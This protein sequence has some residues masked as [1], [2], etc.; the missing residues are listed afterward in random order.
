[1]LLN[2]KRALDIMEQTV[3]LKNDLYELYHGKPI[4][5]ASK[6]TP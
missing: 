5:A 4:L 1:M 6:T 3:K 2:D